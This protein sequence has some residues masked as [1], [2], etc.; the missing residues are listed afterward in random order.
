MPHED[1]SPQRFV[2]LGASNLTRGIATIVD[3]VEQ[4]SVGP[5]EILAA[6]GHGRSYG[7]RSQVLL[8]S[9]PGIIECGL[10]E[11]LA[12]LPA[13]PTAALLT[14]I[15]ND[16]LYGAPV[17]QIVGWIEQVL[18]RLEQA[19]ARAVM[20]LLPLCNLPR[21]ETRRFQ[22]FIKLIYPGYRL[23]PAE[24]TER[25]CALDRRLRE[26]GARRG[27]ALIEPRLEWYGLDPIHVRRRQLA[28]VWSE[29]LS[30]WSADGSRCS[31]AARTSYRDWLRL[32]TTAPDTIWWLNVKRRHPQPALHWAD[33]SSLAF[34]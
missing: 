16:V 19:Q 7:C 12:S 3:T 10:W 6:Q 30:H 25:A 27:V 13:A 32:R 8:R 17:E 4:L 1:F 24:L 11:R 29:I 23:S 21:V 5:R 28:A 18:D 9:L 2:L 26:I 33:G 14:D 20:T 31:S 22:Y 15:G 34:Y